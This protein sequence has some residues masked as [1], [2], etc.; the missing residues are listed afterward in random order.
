MILRISSALVCLLFVVSTA[1][2]QCSSCAQG[3]VFAQGVA[4][5]VYYSSVAY[6]QP[7]SQMS[8]VAPVQSACGSC[9]QTAAVMPAC[10]DCCNSGIRG[11]LARR[12]RGTCTSAPVNNCCTSCAQPVV[13]QPACGCNSVA[14]VAVPVNT[15]CS[16]CAQTACPTDCNTQCATTCDNSPRTRVLSIGSR[17]SSRCCN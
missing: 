12:D 8:A 9:A 10:N 6:A 4:A 7:V 1:S 13:A 11:I 14:P 17:R 3:P 2:A 15:G 16:S 5:P